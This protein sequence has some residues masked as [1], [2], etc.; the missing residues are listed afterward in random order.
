MGDYDKDGISDLMVKFDRADAINLL[1]N[2]DQVT[3]HVTGK[4]GTVTFEGV[5]IIR[6]MK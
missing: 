1:P 6:V 5:D 2:G 3:V 4:V